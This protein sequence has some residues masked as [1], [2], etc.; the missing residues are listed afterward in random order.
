MPRI[1][2]S[3]V[4]GKDIITKVNILN[5]IKHTSEAAGNEVRVSRTPKKFW[6]FPGGPVVKTPCSHCQGPR[7]R[8]LTSCKLQGVGEKICRYRGKKLRILCT[9][10]FL[11]KV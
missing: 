7:F 11:S 9:V 2:S 6:E 10:S 1:H 5:R 4:S 8:E 3:G